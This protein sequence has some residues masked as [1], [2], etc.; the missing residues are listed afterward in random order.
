MTV[1]FAL[2]LAFG[3]FKKACY[4]T[5]SASMMAIATVLLIMLGMNF[6]MAD[7]ANTRA[8]V[9]GAVADAIVGFDMI[10]CAT[11]LHDD[12]ATKGKE[13]DSRV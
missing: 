11:V 7:N 12:A 5:M 1:F 6:S 4:R 8:I 9:A 2:P 13:D 3:M 10:I